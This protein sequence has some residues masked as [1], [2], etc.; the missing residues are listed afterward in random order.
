MLGTEFGWA[1]AVRLPGVARAS[2]TSE[3]ESWLSPQQDFNAFADPR[4]C[5]H[6]VAQRHSTYPAL[7][8]RVWREVRAR[9]ADLIAQHGHRMSPTYIQGL[10]ELELAT[11]VPRIE[12]L[13]RRLAPTGWQTVCVNGYIPS[14]VYAALIS[15]RIFPISRVVR[16]PEHIDFAPDPDLVHD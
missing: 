15:Q 12:Q 1:G 11:Q 4:Q 8:H 2:K 14:E 9:N 5:G 10:R 16:R 7:A 3:R 13:N 6:F